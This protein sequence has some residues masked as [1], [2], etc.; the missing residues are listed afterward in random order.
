MAILQNRSRFVVSVSANEFQRLVF[1]GKAEEIPQDVLASWLKKPMPLALLENEL[2][3][4]QGLEEKA[5]AKA[6]SP[7]EHWRAKV[8][9]VKTT[10]DLDELLK[11]HATESSKAVLKAV[12]ERMA[13]LQESGA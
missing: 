12:E 8:A 4:V 9:R 5:P 10:D 1:P 11:L 2:L 7:K 6:E 3:E 13:E